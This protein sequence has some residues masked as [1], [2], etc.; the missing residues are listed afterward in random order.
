MPVFTAERTL[1]RAARA[2]MRRA[3]TAGA[4]GMTWK[5]YRQGLSARITDLSGRL[6]D[7]T[8]RPGPPR[9]VT[10]AAY[11]GKPISVVVPTVED[12]IVHRAA[13][14]TVQPVLEAGAFTS[15]VSGY[16]P[17]RNRITALRDAA[18]HLHSG[19]IHVADLD[20]AQVSADATVDQAVDWLARHV[21]DGTF[22][23]R[24]RTALAGLPSPLIPGSGLA[25]M[26]INLR[27][28]RVDARLG[29]LAVVRFADNYCVFTDTP[30]AAEVAFDAVTA[31]LAAEGLRPHATKSRLRS[32]PN[33]EDLFL[34]GG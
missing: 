6:T 20:V 7:G 17:S 23:D 26:L 22:L 32:G 16:R 30:S 19:R 12:R 15:W 1:H 24:F 3:A 29:A 2:C 33:V 31:A 13:R 18:E 8:W 28:S 25:P 9:M 5:D 11:T 14:E 27:L 34:I 4:D 10:L 21:Q